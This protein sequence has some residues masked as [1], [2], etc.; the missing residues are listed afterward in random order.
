M[1]HT[2]NNAT[3]GIL[4][5]AHITMEYKLGVGGIKA[6]TTGLIPALSEC[7]IEPSVITPF[8]DV[9]NS[10]YKEQDLKL[11]ATVTH[12]YKGKQF[13]SD[14]FRVCTEV[15]N[16][17]P[18]YHYLI[19][20]ATN[21]LV[22]FIFNILEEKNMYQA[23]KHSEPQNRIEYFNSAVAA[24]LRMPNDLIP[25]F[26]IIH[27][28]TW[29]T[30]LTGCLIKEFE[31]LPLYQDIIK[32][33]GRPLKK[34]PYVIS[35]VHMLLRGLNGS[36]TSEASIRSMLSSLGLPANFTSMFPN[37]SDDINKDHL[38]QIA[39]AMLYSDHVTTVSK[40]LAAEVISGKAEGLDGLFKE[41]HYN[42]RLQGITNG[43]NIKDWDATD[44]ANLQQFTFTS[45][46]ISADKQRIKN[47]L[48][49]IY[50]N[51]DPNKKWYIFIGRFADEKGVEYLPSL[52][53]S[54]QKAN[55][56]LII[57]G[58]HVAFT[59]INGEKIPTYQHLIESL[60][61]PGCVIVDNSIEQKRYGKLFRA[62]SDC[63][64]SLSKNE[65]CGLVPMELMAY[66]LIS[67]VPK[68]QGLTDT[69]NSNTGILY[70]GAPETRRQELDAAILAAA[71]F[72]EYKTK[73]GSIDSLL[74]SLI[75]T[76][77]QYDWRANPAQEY[78]KLYKRMVQCELLT[79]EKVKTQQK[80]QGRVWAIGFNKCGTT[81]MF[82]FFQKNGIPSIHHGQQG[83]LATSIY[84]NHLRGKPLLSDEYNKYKAF[85]DMENIYADPPIFITNTLFK[86]LD[87]NYPGSKFILN[88]R[89]KS[90]WIKS[91]C[92]H[93]DPMNKKR[94]VDVLCEAYGISEAE[95]VARWSHEWDA[96]HAA[97]IEYFKD[98]PQDLLI[99]DI[100][101]DSPEKF[102]EFFK[103]MF[104][105]DPSLYGHHNKTPV[106]H[107]LRFTPAV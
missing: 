12:I 17:K 29:H 32:N 90:D 75:A 11:V 98:R 54:V 7:N 21:S 26:D 6:V 68:I 107:M 106:S 15:V 94:Y 101:H 35:T 92:S 73:D 78:S 93:V 89:D 5:V 64:V 38:K 104:V 58:S 3:N 10:F 41:M 96:H 70:N 28:H 18:I 74:K 51:L 69:V 82:R 25:E 61:V 49:T 105:L 24:M 57:L 44:S 102:C 67:V 39:I 36:L 91:R 72:L 34:I 42:N 37:H 50:P 22:A 27:E 47:H 84:E 97:V 4:K 14:V 88:T 95:L 56:N 99:F 40:G 62:A 31:N 65:A 53:E 87:A 80:N 20:P 45:G 81:T 66:G 19:K 52:L 83:R 103:D 48:T 71:K 100:D 63:G 85:F 13:K 46:S 43:I 23:F 76:S 2:S 60:K 16:N 86:E 33:A 8:F 55:G 30:G 59:N 79:A 77:S 1:T 9:Y